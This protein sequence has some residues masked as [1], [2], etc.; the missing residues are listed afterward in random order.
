MGIFL[1][2]DYHLFHNRDFIYKARGFEC[3]EDMSE[4]IVKRHNEVVGWDDDI[5]LLGDLMLMNDEKGM[6][7]LKRLNGRIHIIIGNHDSDNRIKKYFDIPNVIQVEYAQRINTKKFNFYLTHY[8]T[9]CANFGKR[10]NTINLCGHLHTK[11]KWEQWDE[12]GIYHV[13]FDAHGRPISLD[14]V[15]MDI[16]GK[17]KDGAPRFI[18]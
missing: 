18:G 2:S 5:Y 14:E 4:A 11:D 6:Q 13:D 8:P 15:I 10:N 17:M 7:Y 9:L 1:S 12:F 3:V 16:E